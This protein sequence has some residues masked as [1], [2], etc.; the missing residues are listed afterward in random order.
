M[1]YPDM[2]DKLTLLK[3]PKT[4]KLVPTRETIVLDIKSET[5]FENYIIRTTPNTKL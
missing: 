1:A 3:Y 5:G 2:I 4:L